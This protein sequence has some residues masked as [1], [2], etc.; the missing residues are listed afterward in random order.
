MDSVHP[1][2]LSFFFNCFMIKKNSCFSFFASM[3][4]L[5][6]FWCFFYTCIVRRYSVLIH[7][8]IVL[9]H[10]SRCT[11][12]ICPFLCFFY[13]YMT[14]RGSV[15]V[16]LYYNKFWLVYMQFCASLLHTFFIVIKIII[17]FDWSICNFVLICYILFFIVI[18]IITQ[19]WLLQPI[20]A[21]FSYYVCMFCSHIFVNKEN[22]MRLSYKWEV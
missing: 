18:K 8:V 4:Y 5:Y 19:C 16:F 21:I 3:L 13:T 22:L 17:N 7:H 12:F 6:A 15:H 2:F 9:F 10:F 20:F 11:L 1:I 14:W